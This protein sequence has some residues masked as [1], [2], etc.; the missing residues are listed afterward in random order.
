MVTIGSR[1]QCGSSRRSA[2]WF[3]GVGVPRRNQPTAKRQVEFYWAQEPDQSAG[4]ASL[5]TAVPSHERNVQDEGQRDVLGV[6]RFGPSK[7]VR[8]LPGPSAEI[9]R[10]QP[11]DRSR[12]Q[13]PEHVIGQFIAELAAIPLLMQ[14]RKGLRPEQW[15]LDEGGAGDAVKSRAG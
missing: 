7:V 10:V 15:W 4:A 8:D 2:N 5:E 1:G 14:P 12:L 6:I 9:G 3:C 11:F 13:G